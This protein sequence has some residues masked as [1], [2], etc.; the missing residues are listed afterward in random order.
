MRKVYLIF[1]CCL[2]ALAACNN[3]NTTNNSGN[4][5]STKAAATAARESAHSKLSNAGTTLLMTVVTK[6][7]ALKNALVATKAASADTTAM[8]LVAATDSLQSFLQNNYSKDDTVTV[9]DKL[10]P[11][12]DTILTQSKQ[13]SAVKDE[14]C[15]KQRLAFGIVSSAVYGLL[16]NV[17]L[18][19][20]G[21]YHEYCPMAFNEKGA[22]WLSDDPDIKNPYFGKKMMECGEVMDSL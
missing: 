16:K 17:D 10:H 12:L 4:A 7:Y 21:I 9:Y 20:A 14:T 1:S 22:F 5:D 8:E 13:V 2:L 19:N 3:G 6:Y 11:Y 15:E 18:K